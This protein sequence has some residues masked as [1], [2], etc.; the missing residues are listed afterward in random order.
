MST[1]T[2]PVGRQ[3]VGRGSSALIGLGTVAVL[4]LAWE[5]APRAGLVSRVTVPTPTD[6]LRGFVQLVSGGYWLGHL[7]ST[8]IAVL[9][10]FALGST[11]GFTLG[12]VLGISPFVRRVITPYVIALQALPKVVLAP[13]L[14]GWLGFGT[15]SKIAVATAICFFPVWVNTMVGL[16]L[17][18]A[19]EFRLM[20]S[21]RAS[22]WRVFRMLQLPSALPM[23]LVGLKH[24]LLLAFTGV[25]VAEILAGSAGGL[26]QLAESFAYQ[27]LMPLAFAVVTLVILIAV[28]LVTLVD[29]LEHRIVFWTRPEGA[30]ER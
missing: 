30:D 2:R 14:I 10:A 5:L 3:W 24:A 23:V 11:A 25:L 17:P 12:T 16:A 7:R 1:A 4:L 28:A 19:D 18:G 13:L 6:T 8:L 9:A 26:G 22:R 15:P 27:L 20:T 21:L 29:R